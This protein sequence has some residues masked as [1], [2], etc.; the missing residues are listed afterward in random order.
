MAKVALKVKEMHCAL[1]SI[2]I[3]KLFKKQEGI[4]WGVGV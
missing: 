3:D 1:C 4:V 2:L